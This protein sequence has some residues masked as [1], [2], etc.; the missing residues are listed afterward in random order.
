LNPQQRLVQKTLSF[1][2]VASLTAKR[3]IDEVNVHRQAQEKAAALRP[4]LLKYMMA[5]G[6][7]REDQKQAAEA[8]LGSHAE[9]LNLLKLATDKINEMKTTQTHK[10]GASGLGSGQDEK[11]SGLGQRDPAEYDSL[12]DPVVG[13][14]TSFRKA[15]D[16]ALARVL[17]NPA[18]TRR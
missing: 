18:P 11:H 17:D 4:D 7:V 9:T 5:S 3:A 16:D 15:S 1:V 13:R 12:K 14:R 2:K 8:M 10:P 6:L